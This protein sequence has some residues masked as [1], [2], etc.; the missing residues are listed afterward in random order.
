MTVET[1]A[2]TRYRIEP[3]DGDLCAKIAERPD[4]EFVRYEDAAAALT[5]LARDLETARQERDAARGEAE[6]YVMMLCNER[7]ANIAAVRAA[8]AETWG[9]LQEIEWAGPLKLGREP[10]R[11]GETMRVPIQTCP[12]CHR[13]RGAGHAEWCKVADAIKRATAAREGQ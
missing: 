8:R 1:Q 7:A 3:F 9:M 4:G 2:L 12:A 5:A 11:D 13:E 6:R 10:F